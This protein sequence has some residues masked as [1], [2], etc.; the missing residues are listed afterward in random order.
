MADYPSYLGLKV[1][2]GGHKYTGRSMVVEFIKD[3]YQLMVVDCEQIINSALEYVE[4]EE[5]VD[6]KKDNKKDNKQEE[7]D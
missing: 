3:K 1:F 6:T 4:V 5:V 7:V 2:I